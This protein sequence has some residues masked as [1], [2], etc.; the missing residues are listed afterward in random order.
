MAISTFQNNI[1]VISKMISRN[2]LNKFS[3]YARHIYK[4][5]GRSLNVPKIA[6]FTTSFKECN[7]EENHLHI[8][9]LE[10]QAKY[11][12]QEIADDDIFHNVNLNRGITGVFDIA[13]LVDVLRIEN[14]EDI[15]V[16]EVPSQY[17]YVDHIC[18]VTGKSYRH[19]YAI[20]QFVRQVYKR[21]RLAHDEIPVLEGKNSKDWMAL[22][23]G[24]IALHIFSKE[25]R[26]RYDMDSLWAV[27]KDFDPESNKADPIVDML[28]KHSIYLADLKPAT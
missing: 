8:N 25:A 16:A 1:L 20:A 10:E 3:T 4:L 15:F 5:Q 27:G 7:N 23:L 19:M 21:K 17:N 14:S 2:V 18:I 6:S 13:D 9:V 26:I 11:L 24:N 12:E 22:D 28:E